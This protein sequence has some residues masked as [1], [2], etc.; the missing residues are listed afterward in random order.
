MTAK[1]GGSGRVGSGREPVFRFAGGVC[2]ELGRHLGREGRHRPWILV[3]VMTDQ[4]YSVWG[5]YRLCGQGLREG[6]TRCF[7]AAR[8]HDD[9]GVRLGFRSR[10]RDVRPVGRAV[11]GPA[12]L[13]KAGLASV[14]QRNA[15]SFRC[16]FRCKLE[17]RQNKSRIPTCVD[18]MN[19]SGIHERPSFS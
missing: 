8:I 13:W 17:I 12:V 18:V 2:G 16:V 4:A 9:G 10:L 15:D 1:S 11:R 14:R 3:G 7:L 19:E 5:W 6:G